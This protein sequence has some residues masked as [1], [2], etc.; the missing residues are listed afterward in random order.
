M[1]YTDNQAE[2]A[3]K[4]SPEPSEDLRPVGSESPYPACQ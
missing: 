2:Y 4:Y 1:P 3:A